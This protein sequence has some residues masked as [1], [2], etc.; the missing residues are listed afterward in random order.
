MEEDEESRLGEGAPATA[1]FKPHDKQH[2]AARLQRPWEDS[3]VEE[4][5]E[6]ERGEVEKAEVVEWGEV[7]QL[8]GGVLGRADLA[9][10]LCQPQGHS[11]HNLELASFENIL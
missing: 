3:E 6:V 2:H 9:C 5:E 4:A 1:P 11:F 8:Q 7:C 10:S